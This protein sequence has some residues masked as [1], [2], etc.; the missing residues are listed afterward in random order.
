MLWLLKHQLKARNVQTRISVIGRLARLNKPEAW[1]VLQYAMKDRETVVR[2]AAIKAI[3]KCSNEVTR[4]MLTQGLGDQNPEVRSLSVA[5][6]ASH[7]GSEI[8]PLIVPMLADPSHDV[9]WQTVKALESR[10]WKPTNE[11]EIL[12]HWIASG[13]FSRAASLGAKAVPALLIAMPQHSAA[14]RRAIVEVL[15]GIESEVAKQALE[16]SLGDQDSRVRL[17]AVEG[18]GRSHFNGIADA[19]EVALQDHAYFVRAAAA[20]ILGEREARA[21]FERLLPLATEPHLEVR[22]AAIDALGKLKDGR[23]VKPLIECLGDASGEVRETAIKSLAA[24]GD[25]SC[26]ERLII[27]LLDG[28][29]SVRQAAAAALGQL[30]PDWEQSSAAK[31]TVSDLQHAL[32][33]DDYWIRQSAADTLARIARYLDP[34]KRRESFGNPDYQREKLAVKFLSLAVGDSDRDLRLAA[35]EA[36]GRIADA[37]CL[38]PLI[39]TMQDPDAWV[40][41]AA[42]R[43]LNTVINHRPENADAKSDGSTTEAAG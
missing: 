5:V 27:C 9:C 31:N 10:G 34:P 24:L 42:T 16:R 26:L 20:R 41:Q 21:S 43:S 2:L 14:K 39:Q 3:G 29:I 17:A 7:P 8:I 25:T 4:A 32:K 6:L 37:D 11:N 35:T 30:A 1:R 36:L 13:D 28:R 22:L 12:A 15:S 23:A 40:R 38:E 33:S 18:L 19:L